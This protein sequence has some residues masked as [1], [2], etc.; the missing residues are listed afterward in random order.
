MLK[1]NPITTKLP[2]TSSVRVAI[3]KI[4]KSKHRYTT[5]YSWNYN[6]CIV[7]KRFKHKVFNINVCFSK[8]II[9][10]SKPYESS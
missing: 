4:C 6:I 9:K 3:R 7:K 8:Q 5:I 10:L 1:P 2:N